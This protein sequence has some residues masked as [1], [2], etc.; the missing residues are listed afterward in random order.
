MNNK[1]LI[2]QSIEFMEDHL[3]ETL[4]LEGIAAHVGLSPFHFHRVFR[5]EVGMSIGDYIRSRRLCSASRELLHG[6]AGILEISLNYGFESQEAFTRA[7]KRMYGVPPGRYRKLFASQTIQKGASTMTDHKTPVKGW[8]LS[9]SHPQ[10]Y[11]IGVDRATVHQGNASGYLKS[12]TVQE[13]AEFATLMQQFKAG[14][15]LGK[16]MRM[17]A[18]VK[19]SRV[20]DYCGLWMRVDNQAQDVLQFDNMNNRP[21]Q[22]D[23]QWNLYSIVL[24][25]PDTSAMISFGVLLMGTGQVWV[26]GFTFEEVDTSV[27]TTNL[28]LDYPLLDEPSNL[29]FE[30]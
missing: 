10:N 19:T 14:K 8:I 15:Y 3:E 9:G 12:M 13:P 25:I 17:S 30:E 5:R 4:R 29:S 1:T 21:I 27:P 6:D 2:Q 23:T 20:K 7:F 24:D 18:F 16:R 28:E 11:E 26:D 22:G